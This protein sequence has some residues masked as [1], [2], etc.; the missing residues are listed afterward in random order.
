MTKLFKI[1]FLIIGCNLLAM[2]Q[3]ATTANRVIYDSLATNPSAPNSAYQTVTFMKTAPE[4]GTG[5]YKKYR[6]NVTRIDTPYTVYRSPAILW[7][8]VSATD[9]VPA[10]SFG[11]KAVTVDSIVAIGSNG[12]VTINCY[13]NTAGTVVAM[14]SSNYTVTTSFAS[15]PGL[16]NSTVAAGARVWASIKSISTTVTFL[17]IELWYHYTL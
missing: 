5:F 15:A 2:G 6:G 3:P 7:E 17:R 14:L 10:W 1:L 16:Q 13:R 9:S 4:G 8:G 12:T 11:N